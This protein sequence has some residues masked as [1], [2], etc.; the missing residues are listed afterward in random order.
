MSELPRIHVGDWFS[1]VVDWADENL[2]FAL[3]FVDSVIDSSVTGISDLF[4]AVPAVGLA[5]ILSVLGL[6]LRGWRFGL[7]S[8]LGLLLVQSMRL[9]D[10]AMDSLA[11]IIVASICAMGIALPLGVLAARSDRAS[12]VVRPAM[13][14]MQTMPAFVYLIPALFFFSIGIVPGVMATI[15]FAMPPGVRLTE[16]GLRQVDREMVEAGH[17]FGAHPWQILSRVQIP[18]AMPTIMAGVNQVI[19]LALS[20]VV[21][22]G[23]VGAGGLG[24]VVYEGVTR[25]QL[26]RGF[27]GGLAVVIL[28]VYLD[29]LTGSLSDRSAVARAERRT[30][31]AI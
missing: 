14:L 27:E 28:A 9:W 3:D 26:S 25:L 2:A 4:D 17:A 13:D 7:F 30:A 18:L 19:M 1:D 22:A 15:V 12:Q 8:I 23:M 11:L 20:M 10:P 24:A 16:L 29:R 31:G 5:V 21:I 6:A